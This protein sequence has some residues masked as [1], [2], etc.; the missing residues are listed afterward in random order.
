[1]FRRRIA[2]GSYL[3]I[4]AGTSTGTDP[5]LLRQLQAAY[6]DT[7]PVTGRTVEEITAWFDGFCLARPGVVDVW[8]WRPD[9]IARPA[10]SR[11]RILA[12][13]GRKPARERLADVSPDEAGRGGPSQDVLRWPGR[14]RARPALPT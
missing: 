3:V 12:G 5:E 13:V 8:A 6:G 7:A 2:P 9:S 11:A 1:M 4:S 14:V 10:Q